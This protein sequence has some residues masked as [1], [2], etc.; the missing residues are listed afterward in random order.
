VRYELRGICFSCINHSP[1]DSSAQPLQRN[2]QND[3][4]LEVQSERGCNINHE[5][6]S[7]SRFQ[8]TSKDT[9]D[10]QSHS[11]VVPTSIEL[12]PWLAIGLV[13]SH[14]VRPVET[15]HT[16][17]GFEMALMPAKEPGNPLSPVTITRLSCQK[18]ALS[19]QAGGIGFT[20]DMACRIARAAAKVEIGG[21]ISKHLGKGWRQA[22]ALL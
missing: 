21:G 11:T 16:G 13:V 5:N 14:A 15:S 19:G 3:G 9:I 2:I 6:L 20:V 18:A 17:D 7:I 1:S 4:N 12:A 22:T 10:W 8:P